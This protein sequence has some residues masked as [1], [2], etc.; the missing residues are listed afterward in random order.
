MTVAERKRRSRAMAVKTRKEIRGLDAY[1]THP[2]LLERLLA[3]AP[4]LLP[5][6]V[7]EPC[8]GAGNLVRVLL[9]AGRQVLASDI[10]IYSDCPD[11]YL[12][13]FL[14][15]TSLPFDTAAIVTN[16]PYRGDMG[17]T[18]ARHALSFGVPVLM[19]LPLQFLVGKSRADLHQHLVKVWL[20]RRRPERMHRLDHT[21]P[22]T[23]AQL[24]V[25]WYLFDPGHRGETTVAWL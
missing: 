8:C 14:D 18:F 16:P 17:A 24:D 21:G 10:A 22:K 15:Y 6:V 1:P 11:Q 19:L 20:F 23:D 7:W 3:V 4:S 5:G 9:A 25:G 12:A 2:A 13:D